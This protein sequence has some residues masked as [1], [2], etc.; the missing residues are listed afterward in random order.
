MHA[1]NIVSIR[2]FARYEVSHFVFADGIHEHLRLLFTVNAE[3]RQKIGH[4]VKARA[5]VNEPKKK[6]PIHCE[7]ERGRDSTDGVVERASPKKRLLGNVIEVPDYL[8]IVARQ[9]PAPHLSAA[10]VNDY[11]VSI[12]HVDV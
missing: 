9:D 10:F 5:D 4:P 7:L 1:F 11:T 3:A 12:Y 6:I 8:G 2:M